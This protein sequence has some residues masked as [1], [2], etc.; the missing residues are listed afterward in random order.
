MASFLKRGKTWQYCVSAK[1]KPI[2][3]GGF[4]TKK[5]A[6][7]AAAEVEAKLSKGIAPG[8]DITT[9]FDEY[10]ERWVKLY[11]SRLK[12]P[13]LSHYAYTL[14]EIRKYFGSMPIQK[15]KRHD[16]QEFLNNYGATKGQE[17]VE[18]LHSHIKACV[19]DAI[20][21]GI[22][23]INFTRKAVKTWTVPAKKD[24]EK[25]LNYSDSIR[26]TKEL[27]KRLDRG[28]GYYL[29][30]LGLTS[31]LRFGESV[32]LTRKDFDFSNNTITVNKTW[33]YAKRHQ[34]GF[35]PTKNEQSNR[36]VKMNKQTMMAF[37]HLFEV[38]PNNLHG[39]VFYSASSKYKVISNTNVNKLLRKVLTELS[40]TP[41]TV[42]GL[43]HT[44]ASVLLYRKVSIYYVSARL[45]HSD[46]ETTSSTYAHL[47]KELRERD[48]NETVN[49]FEE[50]ASDKV[51]V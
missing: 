44:H 31:G 12:G 25:Y 49:I 23:K 17:S 22:I 4:T 20:E 5:E 35:G 48:E 40:I 15:I 29:L 47:I 7:I 43:R 32:A 18:K 45:G 46:I 11:R 26:L 37:Q 30:L 36:V 27:Y 33:G 51:P 16:Y 9:P 50:M 6:M 38:T 13:T 19:E 1:P 24:E 14:Q 10:F 2:R 41:I 21:E 42:H 39:L 8:V 34:S 28:L 3:K